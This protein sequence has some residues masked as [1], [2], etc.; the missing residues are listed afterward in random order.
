LSKGRGKVVV[1]ANNNNTPVIKMTNRVQQKNI[2]IW[3]SNKTENAFSPLPARSKAC[4]A[5]MTAITILHCSDYKTIGRKFLPPRCSPKTRLPGYAYGRIILPPR[6]M[7]T[8]AAT[9]E[10]PGCIGKFSNCMC[11]LADAM[12][13][14]SGSFSNCIQ[15]LCSHLQ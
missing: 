13:C 14:C 7:H 11:A 9:W 12:P 1:A 4:N 10:L 3:N 6:C 8:R 5:D 2:V 15:A